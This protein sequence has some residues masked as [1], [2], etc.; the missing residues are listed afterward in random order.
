MKPPRAGSSR[1]DLT[2][3][4]IGCG[5]SIAPAHLSA[6]A[7]VPAARVVGLCGLDGT[8]GQRRAAA[9]GCPFFADHRA[10]LSALK[11]DVAVVCTPHT[12]HA[13]IAID[14]LNAGAH[15]LVE[16]PM[17]V[18]V[19][20]GDAMVAAARGAGRHLAVCFQERFRPA[21]ERARAFI[22]GGGLG[23]LVRVLCVEPL[24][25]TTAYY[26]CAPWR[27]TWNGEG[28]GVL[29]NQAAHTLDLVAYLVGLPAKVTGWTRTRFHSI[30]CEDSAQAM[31]EYPNGAPGYV[32]AST[33]EWG[34]AKQVQ[35]VGDQAC[36]ELSGDKLTI[37]RFDPALSAF[38]AASSDP[39]GKPAVTTDVIDAGPAAASGHHAVHLDFSDAIRKG[40]EPRCTGH[41]G[42]NSLEI[43]NAIVLSSYEERTVSL[44]LDRDAYRSLLRG[45]KTGWRARG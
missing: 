35:I 24:L 22:A 21:V 37:R 39:K 16:K 28:G 15:V 6:I 14:F 32:T 44:P 18:E 45:L 27:G 41:G 33:A 4:V 3:A 7:K 2:Y 9:V 29:L 19:T 23:S 42:L 10:L 26:R 25:R 40:R 13:E 34:V 11:P 1:P 31:F 8:D 5:A 17:A 43:A 30:E 36:V 12:F 38:M 20:E